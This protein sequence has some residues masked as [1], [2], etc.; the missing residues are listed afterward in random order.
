MITALAWIPRGVTPAVLQKAEDNE[1]ML[2]RYL[3]VIEGDAKQEHVEHQD[4]SPEDAAIIAKYDFDH[5]D[6]EPQ[7]TGE[8]F[9]IV[10]NDN[11]IVHHAKAEEEDAEDI[12]RPTDYLIC[13]GKSIEPDSSL[14]VHIFDDNEKA[15]Y[16]HHE[17]L[18]PSFP[19]SICWMDGAP[20][21]GEKGS[22]CAVSTMLHH[23][24]IWNMNVIESTI[25]CAWLQHH[26]D[27]VPTLSWNPLQPR[28]LL[29]A[30]IDGTAA[31]WHLDALR[32]AAVFNLG[33]Q[34]A[35]GTPYS[36][37]KSAE[38]NPKQRSIFGVG[39]NE[40]VFGYDARSGLTW[41][42]LDGESIDT[43][44]WLNDGNQFL[45]STE[46]GKL[47]WF[48]DRNA[49]QPI[50]IIESHDGSI[51][52]I[53]VS[54]YQPR[55]IV[56]TTDIKGAAMIWDLTSGQAVLN[57]RANMGIGE[58]FGCQFCPD[59][60]LLLAIGGSSAETAIWDVGE[61]LDQEIDPDADKPRGQIAVEDEED[62]EE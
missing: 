48:D 28:A 15:F 17:L 43:F 39:T 42:A 57:Q 9:G 22:F 35:E 2:N 1:E 23:I 26:R 25:P 41:S 5:Y 18:I 14:E 40:G 61:D 36:Q 51:T 10:E 8:D 30:S 47:F 34:R 31:I 12:I 20:G 50:Q 7:Q 32:T 16:P 24:E 13:I 38:W 62:V 11:Y 19:L 60:P 44:S 6:D 53:A 46:E 45:A 33:Q 29:S 59:K 54:R 27:A 58:L 3:A 52:G 56:A 21:S 55:T 37:G 4:I 49:A